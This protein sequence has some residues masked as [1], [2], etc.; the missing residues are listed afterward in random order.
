MAVYDASSY[1]AGAVPPGILGEF[2]WDF[3]WLGLLVASL[4][5]GFLMGFLDKV[6][7]NNQESIF[8]KVL[9]SSSLI[10]SGMSIMGSGFVSFIVGAFLFNLTLIFDFFSI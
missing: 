8:I 6:F 9:F 1:G 5:T 7:H 3:S 2:F 4:I 10:W